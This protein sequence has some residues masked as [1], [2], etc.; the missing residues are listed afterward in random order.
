MN[1]DEK[2]LA[3]GMMAA[4]ET[5]GALEAP[6]LAAGTFEATPLADGTADTAAGA[7]DGD[8]ATMLENASVLEAEATTDGGAEGA[9]ALGSWDAE[10][11]VSPP[12]GRD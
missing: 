10:E 8:P 7:E 4:D 6:P 9:A 11:L 5:A 3:D 12:W 1:T 2:P